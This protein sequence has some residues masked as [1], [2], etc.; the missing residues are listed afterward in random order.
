[1]IKLR[2]KVASGL[3]NYSYWIEQYQSI[4]REKTGMLLFPGTLNIELNQPLKLRDKF[5][6]DDEDL[7]E[8][9]IH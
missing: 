3:G 8:V 7:V 2:G 4:Y 5:N 1:L 9:I 6:L